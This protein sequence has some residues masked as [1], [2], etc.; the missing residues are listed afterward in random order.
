M[1]WLIFA[2][3]DRGI[4]SHITRHV[5]LTKKEEDFFVSILLPVKLKQ[6]EF[7]EKASEITYNFI[8]VN[9]GCLMTYLTD[10]EGNDQVIQFAT[11]G[12]WTGDLHSLTTQQPSIYSTRALADS[13]VLL[14]PKVRMEELLERYPVFERYFRIM[15]QNSLVTHQN[16]LIEAFSLTADE[17][18]EQFQKKYPQLEQFVPL[19]YIASY[20][21]ITPEFLSKIRRKRMSN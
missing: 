18:Y 4:L 21:G 1:L 9:S 13:E 19:K 6:G 16:R 20:L 8:H 17:R 15:F 2:A 11:S 7:A 10:K 5:T 3:M 14:L 12:W